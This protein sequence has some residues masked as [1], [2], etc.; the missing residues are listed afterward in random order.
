MRAARTVL[1]MFFMPAL[2]MLVAAALVGYFS[3]TSLRAEY[4]RLSETQVLD[5]ATLQRAVEFNGEIAQL[6]NRVSSTLTGARQRTLSDIQLYRMH[7]QL[8][9]ELAV[10][11]V[12]VD[13][14]ASEALLLEV[15]HNSARGLQQEFSSFRNLVIMATEI[16][17]IDADTADEYFVR[18][19]QNFV[20][21]SI[22]S[23]RIVNLLTERA[24]HRHQED[25]AS[26]E[27]LFSQILFFSVMAILIISALA[28][29][30]GEYI[31]R[32]ML[33]I[34]DALS[35]L[36]RYQQGDLVLPKMA[37]LQQHSKGELGRIA[38]ALLGFRDAIAR[39]IQAEEENHR[40][41]YFDLLTG[42][43]NRRM[44]A[45]KLRH[46]IAVCERNRNRSA[47]LW[48][49]VDRF[50]LLNDT[51]GHQA[52]DDFLKTLSERL[53]FL[54]FSDESLA[55]VDGDEFTILLESLS[56]S[57][58]MAA[59]IARA[60]A[61]KISASLN[62]EYRIAGHSHYLSVSIGI[63]MFSGL[64]EEPDQLMKHAEIAKYQ[65]KARG[66][67]SICFFDPQLQT[68][69]ERR[70]DLE[71]ELRQATEKQQLRLFYQLQLDSKGQA[72][73]A[74]ALLRWLHPKRGLV[75]PA[76]FIP[77][78]EESGL[79]LPM[80]YWVM[81]EACR[82]LKTWQAQAETADLTLSVNVSARQFQ[83]EDFADQ[84]IGLISAHAI[85][86][87]GL[88][89]ELTESAVLEDVEA[90]IEKMH[91]VRALGVRFSMDDFGTGYSSLQYLKRL[92]LD[93]IKID[94]SFVRDLGEDEEDDAI[95]R[96]IIAM[97]Q[98]MSLQVIAEGVETEAQRACLESY[99]CHLYQGYLFSKPLPIEECEGLFKRFAP[100]RETVRSA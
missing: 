30:L 1:F 64:D 32:R 24:Y 86:P 99:G 53:R 11:Q 98:A 70:A 40:L 90:A 95:I 21:F 16:A 97:S 48:I 19:Q 100:W 47:L 50:K 15:N 63:V 80:G 51:R 49:D 77:L 59:R 68:E 20:D 44:L 37:A 67:G 27:S 96:T 52:G 93:Q 22:F 45:E 58:V 66:Q 3:L 65:A 60:Q 81:S 73:G 25:F 76:D 2:L 62:R 69:L 92:P 57:P 72:V 55:R 91:R 36:A 39:R 23:N 87:T 18:A 6:Q 82:Q 89:L 10:L 42:L 61:Q 13:E 29:F 88:K 41:L 75:S 33:D 7:S 31:S 9:N 8:V 46:A 43:P 85:R 5:M 28:M 74:E 35:A 78:A 38:G 54:G 94:Q 83:Q 84:V 4:Q 12:R 34:A 14:L 56:D 26:H 79:I 71:N 17:A